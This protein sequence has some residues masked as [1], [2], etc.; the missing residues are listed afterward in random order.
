[1][2]G[3]FRQA[4]VAFLILIFVSLWFGSFPVPFSFP[5]TYQRID[6][7][8]LV[9]NA[10]AYEGE[11]ISTSVTVIS[12]IGSSNGTNQYS[13][14]KGFALVCPE[15]LVSIPNHAVVIIRGVCRI[16][17]EGI[18]RV[19]E[20]HIE[21]M[22]SSPIRSIPGIVIIAALLLMLYRPSLGKMTFVPRG[23]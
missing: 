11:Q 8:L 9:Q 13:T 17:S 19:E 12:F 7:N 3:H 16:E 6:A 1:M 5:S 23:S 18:V 10:A 20:I 15:S 14:Q 22:L 21:D 2:K 4:F